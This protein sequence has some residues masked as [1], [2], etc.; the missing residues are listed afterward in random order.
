MCTPKS[1]MSQVMSN[2]A[3]KVFFGT[4]RGGLCPTNV[5]LGATDSPAPLTVNGHKLCFGYTDNKT[6]V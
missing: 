4:K 1:P 6:K 5:C 3:V 2:T